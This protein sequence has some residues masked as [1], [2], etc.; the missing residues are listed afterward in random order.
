MSTCNPPRIL[1]VVRRLCF[2][3]LEMGVVNVVRGL[4]R[5]GF[6]QAVCCLE[7]RGELAD[8]VP[9][10]VP[11]WVCA[12][13]GQGVGASRCAARFIRDWR[14]D[15]IHARNGWAWIDA[16]AAWVLSGCCGRLAFSVHGWDRLDHMP[17]KRAFVF[18]QLAKLTKGMA[19]VST[20][21]AR[22]FALE[23]GV[24]EDR[25]AILSSGVDTDVFHPAPSRR[26]QDRIVLGCVGRLDPV[27]AHDVMIAALAKLV[28]AGSHDVE[29][30]LLGDGPCRADLEELVRT[31]GVQDRVRFCGMMSDIPD[32]LR[33]LDIFILS[34]HREGRPTSIMEAMASGLPVVASRVGSI[35]DL[36]ESGETGLLVEPGDAAGLAE[37]IAVLLGEEGKRRQ[38]GAEARRVAVADLSLHRMV[39]EYASFYFGLAGT[40]LSAGVSRSAS[41]N[42]VGHAH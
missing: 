21:T 36:V 22:Q 10:G 5:L 32:Q 26:A 20:E 40:R 11:I 13:A 42:S 31:L 30:R 1:H 23:S 2:G 27:K 28:A 12:E 37:A 7:D 14:P 35:P 17:R 4:E 38:F 19:A 24:A 9:H 25:F 34:S 29:L 8:R 6:P 39:R 33:E 41:A 16:A 15:V 3:G 18:R